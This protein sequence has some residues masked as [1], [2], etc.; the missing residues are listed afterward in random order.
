MAGEKKSALNVVGS[1][2]DET[3]VMLNNKKIQNIRT[4]AAIVFGVAVGIL[5][6]TGLAGLAFYVVASIILSV[7]LYLRFSSVSSNLFKSST[8]LLLDGV[9]GNL[10]TFI[11]FWTLAYGLIH[12]Y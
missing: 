1:G 4:L 11:L 2:V 9:S 3:V 6:L 5:A 10:F 8:A 12:I 7:Y